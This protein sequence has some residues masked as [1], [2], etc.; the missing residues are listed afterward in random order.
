MRMAS[1]YTMGAWWLRQKKLPGDTAM[2]RT[3]QSS[4]PCR[5][6]ATPSHP[7]KRGRRCILHAA[8]SVLFVSQPLPQVCDAT[9]LVIGA[10]S[11]RRSVVTG[12]L[13]AASGPASCRSRRFLLSAPGYG[14]HRYRSGYRIRRQHRVANGDP[15]SIPFDDRCPY[16]LNLRQVL[17]AVKRAVSAPVLDDRRGLGGPDH[18]QSL[19]QRLGIGPVDVN[20]LG[21]LRSRD[22]HSQH[23]RPKHDKPRHDVYLLV[24]LTVPTGNPVGRNSVRHH[25]YT[26]YRV[27]GFLKASQIPDVM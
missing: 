20:R 17:D 16:P 7:A 11:L 26:A 24:V 10:A 6:A 23:Q 13:S 8:A 12:I 14:S 2:C 21:S 9:I 18:R 25:M 3:G 5:P 27:H 19:L 22:P 4:R 15:P 1:P